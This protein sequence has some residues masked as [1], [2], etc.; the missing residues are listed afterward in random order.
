M[1]S[2][3]SPR[4]PEFIVGGAPKCGTTS[5]CDQLAAHPQIAFSRPKE[6]SFFSRDDI[7]AYPIFFHERFDDWASF[8]WASRER[9]LLEQYARCFAHAEPGQLL[10]EGSPSYLRSER[11]ARRIARLAPGTRWIFILRHPTDRAYSHYWHKVS[12]NQAFM[13]F[14]HHLKF[15]QQNT[16][17]YGFYAEPIARIVELFGADRVHVVAFEQMR[18]DPQ[19]TLRRI[20]SFL[21]IEERAPTAD[22]VRTN[23][24]RYPRSRLLQRAIGT[25]GRYVDATANVVATETTPTDRP[26]W[27]RVGAGLVNR[28]TRLNLRAGSPPPMDPSTRAKLDALYTREN[29]QL[30]TLT[31]VDFASL[32]GLDV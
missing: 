18:R 11:A 15:E 29:A 8:A 24:T 28:V 2:I 6:P 4:L 21:G 20:E 12:R 30:S 17:L 5:L 26:A 19:A 9:D 1:T 10:G 13:S 32:W 3:T 22:A 16:L 25:M 31:G 23:A 27:S 14:E 7:A